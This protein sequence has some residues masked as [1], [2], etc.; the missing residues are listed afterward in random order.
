MKIN[1][2]NYEIF[3]LDYYEGN[4][5]DIESKELMEFLE[6]NFDLKDEFEQYQHVGLT[7]TSDIFSEK[8]KLKKSLLDIPV[9]KI[10]EQCI[11]YCEND[12][13]A[14]EK[15]DFDA[16]LNENK[17]IRD[18]V[19]IYQKLKLKPDFSVVYNQ[20]LKLK[21]R[22]I[23]VRKLFIA[24][25]SV[26]ASIFIAV[27]LFFNLN[28]KNN[29]QQISENK[30]TSEQKSNELISDKIEPIVQQKEQYPVHVEETK[31]EFIFNQKKK[32]NDQIDLRISSK[33]KDTEN[34]I[35]VLHPK[36][37]PINNQLPD[38]DIQT[39]NLL[40]KY[41]IK[42]N[43][44]L[45]LYEYSLK[46]IAGDLI[47]ETAFD[48]DETK[49]I[50]WNIVENGVAKLGDYTGTGLQ[51]NNTYDEDGQLKTFAFHSKK[52]EFVTPVNRN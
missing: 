12:Y 4:L 8:L 30:I 10:D 13:S 5:T 52:F 26:A 3:F 48:N 29:I 2:N 21:R 37:K 20:K 31:N 23:P 33:K 17:D 22:Y 25:T 11:A 19:G 34:I 47:D 41:F 49:R 38:M 35:P 27:I 44:E 6:I 7:V 28:N 16:L 36:I 15:H 9:K 46:R 43:N 40:N 32:E 50:I 39:R 1:R 51:V 45:T 24:G 42:K 14:N 18:I